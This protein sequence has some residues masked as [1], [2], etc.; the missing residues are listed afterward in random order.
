MN[1]FKSLIALSI[2]LVT[3]QGQV[4]NSFPHDYPGKP[5]GDLS[6][7]WQACKLRL[8]VMEMLVK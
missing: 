5:G 1:G 6:P 8:F 3:V 2:V 7:E 4:S